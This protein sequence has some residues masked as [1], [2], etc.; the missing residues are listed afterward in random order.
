MNGLTELRQWRMRAGYL[1]EQSADPRLAGLHSAVDTRLRRFT[2][3]V[4]TAD[5]DGPSIGY[6]GVPHGVVIQQLLELRREVGGARETGRAQHPVRGGRLLAPGGVPD[7]DLVA[8]GCSER[9]VRTL[10]GDNA[11]VLPFRMH[12]S[13]ELSGDG[14]WRRGVSKRERQWFNAKSNAC[15]VAV[16]VAD[17]DESFDFFYD[18]MHMPTMRLRHGGRTRSESKERAHECLFRRGLLAFATV[19]GERVAGVLCHRSA[20]R[21]TLTVRLLG[22]RDGD[23]AHHDAGALKVLYHVLLDWA[24]TH[25]IAKVDFGAVEAWISQGIF[26]W[27]RRF[28]PKVALAPNHCGNLRVWWRARRDT[29]AVRDFLV[30]NPVFELTGDGRLCA[31]YF[32]DDER[33]P[34]YDIPFRCANNDASRALHLDEFLAGLPST[35]RR[36]SDLGS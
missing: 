4:S 9:Q 12:L 28:G 31:V 15:D 29:P 10:P 27:K 5:P 13:V 8:V 33:P 14:S 2:T 6:A 25:G 32:H 7:A 36:L 20:D 26:Q 22:V 21:T 18:R 34:R 30:A 19:D 3:S 17:D 24:D 1:W 16:E 35:D 11:L 23:Q